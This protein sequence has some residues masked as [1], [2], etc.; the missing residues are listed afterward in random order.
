M[1]LKSLFALAAFLFFE[2]TTDQ[3][4]TPLFVKNTKT[5][6]ANERG[7]VQIKPNFNGFMDF[8]PPKTLGI[9]T[10]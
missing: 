8:W 4:H 2:K 3:N 5:G 10:N 9:N 1:K 7:E 6:H